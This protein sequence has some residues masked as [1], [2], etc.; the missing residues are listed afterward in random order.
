MTVAQWGT[1][2]GLLSDVFEKLR[3]PSK[4]REAKRKQIHTEVFGAPISAKEIDHLEMFGKIKNHLLMLLDNVQGTVE[5][6]HP[7]E[8]AKRRL[9]T[10]IRGYQFVLLRALDVD[11][12]HYIK[13]IIHNRWRAS[14]LEDVSAVPEIRYGKPGYSPLEKLRMDITRAIQ[15]KRKERGWTVHELHA[16]AE[17]PCPSSTGCVICYPKPTAVLITASG[18][19]DDNVP[20]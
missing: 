8:E 13:P 15:S 11:G 3:I 14:I 9:I 12:D 17:L 4:D 5:T 1:Y 20:F 16:A 19:T 7:E 2:F 6:D 18:E 10:G